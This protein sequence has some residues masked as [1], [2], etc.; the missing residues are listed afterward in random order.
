MRP[1]LAARAAGAPW[2][3]A[4]SRASGAGWSRPLPYARHDVV[5]IDLVPG[6]TAARLEAMLTPRPDAVILR[7]FGVGNIPDGEPGLTDVLA[8]AIRAGTAVVVISQCH[9]G[10]VR[11]GRYAAGDALARAGAVGGADM[12]PEA[13][14]VKAVFL[15]SQGLRGSGLAAWMGRS[16]AGELDDRPAGA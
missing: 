14:Y 15:L 13:A 11:L 6:I 16:I 3:W 2:R 8:S 12:T 4:P 9:Q 10:G 5:V 1:Q 7:A